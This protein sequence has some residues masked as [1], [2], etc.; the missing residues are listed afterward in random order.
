MQYVM[1]L[2]EDPEKE[3][4]RVID[5]KGEPWFLLSEVCTKIGISNPAAAAARLDDD[6][7][8]IISIDTLGGHQNKRIINES[9]L[10]SLILTSRKPEAKQFKKWITSEVLPSIRKT[11]SYGNTTPAFIKRATLNWN[12]VEIG[13]FSVINELAVLVAGRLEMA[14]H[15][16]ADK[17]P[18]GREIRPDNSVGRLFSNWLT[19]KHPD[20]CAD[21]KMY[22]HETPE[23]EGDVRQYPYSILPLFREYVETVWWPERAPGYLRT[24][25]P[26]ALQYMQSLVPSDRLNSLK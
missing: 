5:K 11:G 13:Y 10:Y 3:K 21:Y 17:A 18:D 7:K 9:G 16:M 23:W 8:G 12:R 4:F 1:K 22:S 26:A 19:I 14:G 25:D 20:I 24:R 15:I 6:E 2:F